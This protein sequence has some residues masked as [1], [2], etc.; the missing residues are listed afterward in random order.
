MSTLATLPLSHYQLFQTGDVDEARECVARVFC[1]HGLH[2]ASPGTALDA[3]HH[4]VRLHQHISLNYVQYGPAVRIDP[5]Y[6]G[7]FYLLQIPLRGGASIRC[8][9]QQVLA[10][11]R[12]ASLPSQAAS[13]TVST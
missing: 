7:D 8:G 2:V 13:T 3:R 5:G 6:L 10:N 1:P 11:T 9:R 4:S 12:T